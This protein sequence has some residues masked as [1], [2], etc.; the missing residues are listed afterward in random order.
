[1]RIII[2]SNGLAYRSLYA[3][4]GLSHKNNPT[5]V[6]YGFLSEIF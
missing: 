1:M 5:G 6:I 4:G 3:F 2:D